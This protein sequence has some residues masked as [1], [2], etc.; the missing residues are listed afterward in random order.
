MNL[1]VVATR[2]WAPSTRFRRSFRAAAWAAIVLSFWATMAPARSPAAESPSR[3]NI[4]FV[5]AD[6]LGWADLG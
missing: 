4:V 3:L 2:P 5:L 6:D 1:E